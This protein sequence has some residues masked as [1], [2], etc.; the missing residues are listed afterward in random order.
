MAGYEA[1]TKDIFFALDAICGFGGLRDLPAFEDLSDDLVQAVLG[2]AGK[3]AAEV[4]APLNVVGDREHSKM[5]NGGVRTPKGFKEAYK[6]YVEGGWNALAFA[7]DVGGQGLPEALAVA[8]GEMFG[9][10]NLSLSLCPMLGHSAIEAM[11]AHASDALKETY[12]PKMVS[13]EWTCSM[14]LT[15]PQAGSDVGA[16]KTRAE[17]AGDGS[18]RIVGTKIFISWGEHDMTDNIL[19]FVLARLK[20]APEGAKGISMFLVPKFLLDGDGQPGTRNDVKCVSLE[21]KLGIHASPTCMLSF[22]DEGN[23]VGYLVG[24]E[25]AGMKNMFTMMNIARIN[26]GLQ[27]VSIAEAAYQQALA[28]AEERRQGKAIGGKGEGSDAILQHA[29]VRRMLMTMKAGIEATRALTYLNATA[30]DKARHHPEAEV[31]KTWAGLAEL[32]TPVTKAFASDMGVKAASLGLQ[33]HGGMGYVEETGAAQYFRDAR[34]APIYEGTNGIQAMDLVRR[35]LVMDDGAHWRLLFK[36]IAAFTSDL[37]DDGELGAMKPYL[38]DAVVAVHDAAEHLF[39]R[40]KQEPRAVAAG[41]SPFLEM[42]GLVTG[43][44][45]LARGAEQ[46]LIRIRAGDADKAYLEARIAVAKFYASQ[47]LPAAVGLHPAA[48]GGDGVVFGVA[49]DQM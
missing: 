30:L 45:L 19:H 40:S 38:E 4:F 31:Q 35:K 46:A 48:T 34:I 24:Q 44:Y 25:N 41:A 18:Y 3:L 10:A 20:G 2:E 42:F 13:G 7:E 37:P 15:E 9:S 21:E 22:G 43:G 23:C 28:Y 1:P 32:L 12:L 5:E 16:L 39:K 49:D 36:T 6:A 47:M 17:D 8:V 26:V 14:I 11:L 29:D 27:G 33:V